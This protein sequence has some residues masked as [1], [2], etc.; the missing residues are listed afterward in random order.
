MDCRY[1][2]TCPGRGHDSTPS[3]SPARRAIDVVAGVS[4][5]EYITL[6]DTWQISFP[7]VCSLSLPLRR[8]S[9]L[10]NFKRVQS[11]SLFNFS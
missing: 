4:Q 3:L 11:G 2:V 8:L 7:V 6:A 5:A 1:R 9:S 10:L